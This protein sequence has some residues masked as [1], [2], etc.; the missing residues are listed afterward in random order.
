MRLRFI[1]LFLALLV[2]LAIAPAE[3]QFVNES[4]VTIKAVAVTSGEKPQGA[5]IDITVIVTPGNGRVFVST[6]PYTEIDMQGSAQLAALTACDLLGIDFMQHDFF[7]IIEADAPIVGGPSAGGVMCIATIAALKNLSIKDD[8]FMTGMIYPDGFIG[9]VG[10]IPYKLEAAAS[11][12]AKIFLIPKGQKVVYVQERREERKGPFIFISTTTRPVDVVE[13]GEKLGVKVIEVET[14]EQALTY[15]TGYTIE[16][17]ELTF[18]LTKYSDVLMRLADRMKSDATSLLN[19]V[20]TLAK[21]DELERIQEIMDEAEKCYENGNYYTSTSKYFVAK[22]EMR[23]ILYR[24]TITSDEELSKEFDRV[25]KDIENLKEYLKNSDSIGVESFQLYGAAEERVS[26]AEEYLRK[27]EMSTDRNKALENLAYARER[28]ESARVWLSLLPTIEEDVPLGKDEIKRRAQL[29]LSQA[30]S[31]IIYARA[32]GG[33]SDLINEASDDI[34]VAR[35]QL[36]EG[37][38]CGAAISAMEAI[39]KAS[40][41]IE[42][43]GIE[44][45]RA[46]RELIEAKV[47]AAKESAESSISEL[48]QYVTPIL[49]VAYYEFAETND[50]IVAKLAYY[51]LSERIAKLIGVVAK[52]YVERELVKV[53]HVPLP[54][55]PVSTPPKAYEIPAFQAVEAVAAAAGV[56]ALGF[57]RKKE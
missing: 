35:G 30:E 15:Y 33:Q 20:K 2:A 32:I 3:A 26:L 50:N 36:D 16:K 22:I 56:V 18:N 52:S 10:G 41:S 53:E 4:R 9:P 55:H 38:Y 46:G 29:Y 40:L 23:Y 51:K 45:T 14:V 49:P 28:V 13:Y 37:M 6:T 31:M 34:A 48:E 5:V 11:N 25:E 27:A 57:R 12:G 8:V 42:L 24:H 19:R 7:Y 47:D 44:Y 1:A 17:P 21:S 54:T 39:T 43:I